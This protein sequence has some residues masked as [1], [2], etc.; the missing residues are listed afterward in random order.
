M[1]C[2]SKPARRNRRHWHV[3]KNHLY[4]I[5]AGVVIGYAFADKL[6]QYQPWTLV[7]DKVNGN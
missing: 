1:D 7:I 5:L 4:A 6:Y 3:N 2:E